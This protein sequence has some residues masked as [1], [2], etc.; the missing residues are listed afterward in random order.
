MTEE[1]FYIESYLVG[2]ALG[3]FDAVG[4]Q[5]SAEV[6]LTDRFTGTHT[7]RWGPSYVD[8]PR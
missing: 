5:V 8:S 1:Y 3:T 2:A 6:A 7:L 4:I